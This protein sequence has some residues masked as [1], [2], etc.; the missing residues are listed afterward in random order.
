[1]RA[2]DDGDEVPDAKDTARQTAL[3]ETLHGTMQGGWI[4]NETRGIIGRWEG[5]D[6]AGMKEI[7]V[8]LLSPQYYAE[9]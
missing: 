4:Q 6:E 8:A 9:S 5:R 7:E 1:M 2:W 3:L